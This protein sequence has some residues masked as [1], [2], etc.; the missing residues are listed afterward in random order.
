MMAIYM[1]QINFFLGDLQIFLQLSYSLSFQIV[2]PGRY[3][4]PRTWGWGGGCH[5]GYTV[6]RKSVLLFI[7]NVLFENKGV[8]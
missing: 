6:V 4:D 8:A 5:R 3:G 2:F 1:F 7:C